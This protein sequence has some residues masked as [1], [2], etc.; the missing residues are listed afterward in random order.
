MIVQCDQH[1]VIESY[2]L[3][4]CWLLLPLL[5]LAAASQRRLLLLSGSLEGA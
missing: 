1:T 5:A 4:I 2:L 3:G